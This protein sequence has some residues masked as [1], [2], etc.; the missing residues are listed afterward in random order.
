[1]TLMTILFFGSF[2]HYSVRVLEKLV[3]SFRVIGVVTTP[4]KPKGRGLKQTPTEVSLFAKKNKLPVLE[5]ADLSSVPDGLERPDFLVVAGYGMLLPVNWLA[6]PATMAV[7]MHPS[8]L[9]FYRG[10]FPAEWAILH[11]E[12]ETGVTLVSMSEEFDRGGILAQRVVPI[13]PDDT[14]ETLYQKLYRLGGDLLVFSLPRIAAGEIAPK[15]QQQGNFFYARRLTREDGF[16]EWEQLTEALASNSKSLD[17]TFRAL[18]GWPGIWTKSPQG[19]RL[20]V[21]ALK[22]VPLVQ[23]EGKKSVTWKQFRVA[24]L[25]S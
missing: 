16:M 13:G 18:S 7:N 1:M 17:R 21:V 12:K 14:R 3:S 6:L 9:P 8:L 23:L 20:K 10:A 19:K 4:P 25:T 15:P 11:G 22:P 5:L 2:G 24:Y